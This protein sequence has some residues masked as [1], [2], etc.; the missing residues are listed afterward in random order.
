[1]LVD[2][3]KGSGSSGAAFVSPAAAVGPGGFTVDAWKSAGGRHCGRP[4]VCSAR[5][6]SVVGCCGLGGPE[7]HPK[8]IKKM[9]PVMSQYFSRLD[10]MICED[11]RPS[12]PMQGYFSDRSSNQLNSNSHNITI[13]SPSQP[14]FP[15]GGHHPEDSIHRADGAPAVK[16]N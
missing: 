5:Q 11:I 2:E 6:G 12:F 1:M 14:P 16:I 8:M 13:L 10:F 4:I 7:M 9:D 15:A 3:D